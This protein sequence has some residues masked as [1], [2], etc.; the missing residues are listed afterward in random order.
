[1]YHCAIKTNYLWEGMHNIIYCQQFGAI[2]ESHFHF[3]KSL[4]FD[5]FFCANFCLKLLLKHFIGLKP[6]FGTHQDLRLCVINCIWYKKRNSSP[7][8]IDEN[9]MNLINQLIG[10]GSMDQKVDFLIFEMLRF[11]NIIFCS[12]CIR[13]MN[14]FEMP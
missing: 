5:R 1:M 9:W 8:V 3:H 11:M 7:Y 10:F 12:R 4:N 13:L 6:I 14:R 2:L